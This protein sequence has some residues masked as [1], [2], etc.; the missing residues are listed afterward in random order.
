M[1][2]RN[3]IRG[4]AVIVTAVVVIAAAL[5]LWAAPA[6]AP[7][8]AEP[9][10]A[11]PGNLLVNP[12]FES[13]YGKQCCQTDLSVYLPNTPIDEVQVAQGWSGWWRDNSLPDYPARCDIQYPP[14]NCKAWHRPEWREAAPYANRIHSGL[15][16][17]KY[18]TFWSVHE[19][20]MYQ[21]VSGLK[22]GQRL[23]F[24]AYMSAWSTDAAESLVSSGQ[25]T[26][27][28]KVGIDPYGGT[29]AFSPN[30]V[31]GKPGD[32]YDVFGQF[33]VEAVAQSSAV[34]VFTYSMPIYAIQHNDVYVDDAALVVVG[35]GA[36][37]SPKSASSAGGGTTTTTEATGPYPGTTLDKATGNILY[38]VQADDTTFSIA[39]RFNVT[40]NQI[41]AWNNLADANILRLGK[42]I[43]VGKTK[44]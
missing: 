5:P 27:N 8:A 4:L 13:P 33:T 12:G 16:A 37:A 2:Q 24:S 19:A 30:V 20:G 40:V 36:V 6:D 39:R 42:T 29:D 21:R 10:Q 23:Q 44:R 17:Q 7:A 43:I 1:T 38:V 3:F 18:F 32:S 31:W 41:V 14:P 22:P 15:N 25:Q 34:T 11:V 35:A 26:M 28:L 9:T